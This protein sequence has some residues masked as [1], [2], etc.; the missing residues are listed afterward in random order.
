LAQSL[1]EE[2]FSAMKIWPFDSFALQTGGQ[3]ISSADIKKGLEPF[4]KIR[5]AVGDRIEVMCEFHSL[6]NT[7]TAL[8]IA[9]EL[10]DYNIFWSEDPIKMDSVGALADYRRHAGIPVCGSETLATRSA[11]R[12]LLAADAVDYVMLDLSWC[13]GISEA[14]K[15]AT[16]AEAYQKP[17]APHDCTGPVVLMASLHLGLSSPNAIFQEVVRAYL[18]GFYQELVTTLPDVQNGFLLP[19]T[20]SGLGTKLNP[21]LKQKADAVVR[22]SAL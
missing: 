9:R 17:I 19:P 1:I 7:T 11:F 4:E 6:W 18:A 21:A 15:I 8:A 14:K 22:V 5:K 3:Y 12:D 20:G 10:K 2:G 16:M 13:G